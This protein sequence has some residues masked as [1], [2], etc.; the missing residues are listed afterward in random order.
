M[1]TM[2]R[3]HLSDISSVMLTISAVL[4]I[5]ISAWILAD[6]D[7][8]LR[9]TE[10]IRENLKIEMAR[11]WWQDYYSIFNKRGGW[12]NLTVLMLGIAITQL[13]LSLLASCGLHRRTSVLLLTFI[14]FLLISISLQLGALLLTTR[15]NYE[16]KQF[17]YLSTSRADISRFHF[18]EKKMLLV[19]S[20]VWSLLSLLTSLSALI[21]T[22][23]HNIKGDQEN[24]TDV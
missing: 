7:D 9:T 6:R 8:L 3:H 12:L 17:Y 20:L 21:V 4:L 19:M 16:L 23:K 11:E 13:C 22:D 14:S 24:P 15:R 1:L 2:A 18:P 5:I 10:D